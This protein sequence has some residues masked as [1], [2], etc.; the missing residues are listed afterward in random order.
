LELDYKKS[1]E[2]IASVYDQKD[3]PK[4]A[5]FE[6]KS[7]VNVYGPVIE[8]DIARLFKVFLHTIQPKKIL[9]IGMSIG[10]STTILAKV[11]KLYDGRV[12]TIELNPEAVPHARENFEREGVSDIIDIKIGNAIDILPTIPEGSYD[13]V[14]QD[15]SKRLYPVMLGD[16]LR[17]LRKGGLFLV[18]D[19]LWPPMLPQADWD[20]SKK[21]IHE[22]NRQLVLENVESTIV[23]IGEGCT[24]AVKL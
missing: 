3:N 19:T 18:D 11:A 10:F 2:Y 7:S 9:E 17:I 4:M 24:I 5:D 22:F 1:V 23:T 8:D 6:A 14:F 15:S 13:A 12:T 20:E 16:C 21:G